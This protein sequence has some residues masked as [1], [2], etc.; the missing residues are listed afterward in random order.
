MSKPLYLCD[1][2]IAIRL[3]RFDHATHSPIAKKI[4]ER[5]E[6]GEFTLYFTSGCVAEIVWVM[7]S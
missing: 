7:T 4:F 3:L 2:N 6:A 1:A 5:A